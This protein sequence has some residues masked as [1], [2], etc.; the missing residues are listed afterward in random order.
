METPPS[1][2]DLDPFQNSWFSNF[3]GRWQKKNMIQQVF[4]NVT[5]LS[6][7]SSMSFHFC[8]FSYIFYSHN[9]ILKDNAYKLYIKSTNIWILFQQQ[10]MYQCI[11]SI[12]FVKPHD[13]I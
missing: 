9:I 8:F 11:T 12:S 13:G 3:W 4:N 5:S 6:S 10:T 1:S 2:H 7:S